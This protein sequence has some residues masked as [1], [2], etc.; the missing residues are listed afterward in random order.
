MRR[1]VF[2]FTL[3]LAILL[4]A[5]V[6]QWSFGVVTDWKHEIFYGFPFIYKCNGWHTSLSTQYFVLEMTLNFL[7]YVLFSF[8]IT[9]LVNKKWSIR[10]PK[11]ITITFW[12][13][14]GVFFAAFV[15]FSNEL[16]DIYHLKRD[17]DVE[18]YDRGF[19]V[20]ESHPE[21]DQ[22]LDKYWGEE[23]R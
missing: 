8:L 21:W 9:V 5:L 16:D 4:F 12:S 22:L 11:A 17:F 2:T 13:V 3:P 1:H 6:T 20:M 18:I 15:Y 23:K 14:F 10:I 7:C 19:S